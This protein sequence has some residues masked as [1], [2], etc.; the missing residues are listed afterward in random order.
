MCATVLLSLTHQL[1]L[2][3][4]LFPCL[5]QVQSLILC[6]SDHPGLQGKHTLA[7]YEDSQGAKSQNMQVST[8]ARS[9]A[10]LLLGAVSHTHLGV[11]YADDH[12]S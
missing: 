12:A 8:A 2:V 3:L 10:K 4:G 6:Y 5:G 1:S 11:K 7:Y 9:I